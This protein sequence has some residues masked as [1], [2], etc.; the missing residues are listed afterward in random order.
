MAAHETEVNAARSAAPGLDRAVIVVGLVVICGQIMAILDTTIVNVALDT[1]SRDLH[2]SLS[3]TQWVITGYLLALGL[4]VPLSGWAT[5]RFG[6]RRVW[7][8]ALVLFT[9][10]SALS[11]LAWSIGVLITF[12]VIQGFGGGMML[13]LAQ[14]ILTRA[15]GPERLGRVMALLGVPMLLGPV[16]GPVIGGVLVQDVSWHWIFYVNVPI[17]ILAV[18]L[19]FW[20]LPEGKEDAAGGMFD[21]PGLVLL[22]ASL[23]M[24]L[25]GLSEAANAGGF[26][27]ARVLGWIVGG[28]VCL[29]VFVFYS[30][31]RRDRAVVNVRL[32]ANPTFAASCALMF[33]VA[34]GLFGGLLLIPL[35]YQVVRGQGALNAGLLIAP[36][37]L[38]AMVMMP[39]SGRI[40]DKYGPGYIIPFGI[41]LLMLGTLPFTVVHA[42][43]SYGLL[44]AALVV[45]GLGIGASM[46]PVF[47]AAYR[48]MPR[49]NVPPAATTMS[50]IVQVGGSFGAAVLAMELTRRITANFASHGFPV[51]NGSLSQLSSV[52]AALLARV[53]PLLADGFGY[54]FWIVLAATAAGMVPALLL[55][56]WDKAPAPGSGAPTAAAPGADATSSVI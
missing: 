35:Y 11:G 34:V 18:A 26:S 21:L 38:G 54:A 50:V 30:L 36:Q 32:F 52:P 53:A 10:G 1:L 19:A 5:Q 16:F 14:T 51:S 42:T 2:A 12:R 40:T 44:I 24:L 48:R 47:A 31:W 13:P 41:V 37:G 8:A 23:I 9:L 4:V 46:M 17:G 49:E 27:E 3:S 7:I 33:L 29:V 28:A 22:A 39:L 20:K 15:A 45:R 25:Y 6:T 56:V 43:T 55:L